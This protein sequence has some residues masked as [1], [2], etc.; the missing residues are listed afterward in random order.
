MLCC[1]QETRYRAVEKMHG[2]H[3]QREVRAL[4]RVVAML[5]FK[6]SHVSRS[7]DQG[8][9]KMAEMQSTID[10]QEKELAMF[11]VE[12]GMDDGDTC[13]LIMPRIY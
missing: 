11:K 9:G 5:W 12:G 7:V 13:S 10:R 6:L 4:K 8:G 2:W 3:Q 1:L